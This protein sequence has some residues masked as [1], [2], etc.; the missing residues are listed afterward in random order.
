MDDLINEEE[1]AYIK[2]VCPQAATGRCVDPT[3]RQVANVVRSL[4]MTEITYDRC[5]SYYGILKVE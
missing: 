4:G 5:W 1:E 3:G 2:K